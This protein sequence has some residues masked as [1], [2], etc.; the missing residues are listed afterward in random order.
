MARIR[1]IKPEFWTDDAITECSTSARLLFIGMWNFS[2]DNG[3]IDRSAKQ[4]KMK[5]F[6][7]DNIDAEPLLQELLAQNLVI[8]YQANGCLFLHIRGFAKHQ[9]VDKPSKFS[10]PLYSD[11]LR[12]QRVVSE[13]STSSQRGLAPESKV[14]EGKGIVKEEAAAGITSEGNLNEGTAKGVVEEK[15]E[16][17]RQPVLILVGEQERM[18]VSE[19]LDLSRK[20]LGRLME[21]AGQ[22]TILQDI[23]RYY[24][25][26][27]IREAFAAAQASAVGNLG[28]VLKRLEARGRDSPRM[29]KDDER[30]Q[31]NSEAAREFCA[32]VS[33]HDGK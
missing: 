21:T 13:D 24:S 5:I 31:R 20:S 17:E 19:A 16:P 26:E 18:P 15:Q 27:R 1:T 30:R 22:V 3:N 25:P 10:L 33:G 7:A 6:P 14:K 8:E 12:T 29:T 2:D 9:K 28:W 32:E 11:S 4:L 23:C